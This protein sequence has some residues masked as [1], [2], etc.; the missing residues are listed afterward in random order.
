MTSRPLSTAQRMA[1]ATCSA[2]GTAAGTESERY[3]QQLRLGR[4]A[5]HA[6]A[7]GVTPA[8]RERRD[9]GAVVAVDRP[10]RGTPVRCPVAWTSVPPATASSKITERCV[11]VSITAI[12]APTTAGDLPCL[13]DARAIEPILGHGQ[14]RRIVG[15]GAG[16]GCAR[17][18]GLCGRSSGC[19]GRGQSHGCRHRR[20]HGEESQHPPPGHPAALPRAAPGSAHAHRSRRPGRTCQSRIADRVDPGTGSEGVTGEGMQALDARGHA[21]GRMPSISGTSP[22]DGGRRG[23]HSCAAR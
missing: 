13:P 10:H 12:V 23:T 6:R 4:D 15:D 9:P 11:P 7:V 5:D 14:G 2:K 1:V 3:R 8:R 17:R 20:E 21:A 16:R 22:T 19:G 18:C